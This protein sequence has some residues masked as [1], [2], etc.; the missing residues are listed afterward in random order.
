[1]ARANKAVLAWA[2]P[3]VVV[4][5]LSGPNLQGAVVGS[6]A[7]LVRNDSGIPQMGALVTLLNGEGR[8]LRSVYTNDRGAFVLDELFPGFYGVK[9]SVPSLLPAIK[10]KILIQPGV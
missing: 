3:A 1:M 2:F 8:I 7:G 6:I 10:E 5:L 9:V 4:A